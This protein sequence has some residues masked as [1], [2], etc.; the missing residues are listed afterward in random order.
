ML[1]SI[2]LDTKHGMKKKIPRGKAHFITSLSVTVKM[3]RRILRTTQEKLLPPI[4]TTILFFQTGYFW[5]ILKEHSNSTS[6]FGEALNHLLQKCLS[7]RLS[8][9][10][11][12]VGIAL[13]LKIRREPGEYCIACEHKTRG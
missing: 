5:C 11:N 3:V 10:I 7:L 13:A 8:L 6:S 9:E 2:N 1:G 4:S 12:S